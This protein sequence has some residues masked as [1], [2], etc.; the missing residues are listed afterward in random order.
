V[1]R[2]ARRRFKGSQA[3][4][5]GANNAAF[6]AIDFKRDFCAQSNLREIETIEIKTDAK[7]R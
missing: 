4:R 5:A 3:G 7:D 2:G 6:K 1:A